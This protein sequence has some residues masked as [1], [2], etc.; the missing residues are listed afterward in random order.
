M[1]PMCTMTWLRRPGGYQ[2][3]FNRDERLTRKPALPPALRR[4]G[5]RRFVAPLDGDF[6]G[7]WLAVNDGGVTLALHN[8]YTAARDPGPEPPG[9]Y[10]SR[11][12]LV[13]SLADAESAD[14]VRRRLRSLPLDSFRGF[15]LTTFGPDGR[16]RLARWTGDELVFAEASER[17]M[18]LVSSSFDTDEV[19]SRRVELFRRLKQ[20]LNVDPVERHLA[21]H[22]SHLP[23]RGACSPCMHRPDAMTVS[24]NW[25]LVTPN[26]VEYRYSPRSPCHGRPVGE[27]VRLRRVP[28]TGAEP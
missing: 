15:L 25:I 23:A 20:E 10:T 9:G 22:E 11:G 18:P 13:L 27:A 8:A 16:P 5:E 2:V 28:P 1:A 14:D 19:R 7:T 24:F 21:Y 12:L 26:Q 6:G 3:F 4:V 17:S